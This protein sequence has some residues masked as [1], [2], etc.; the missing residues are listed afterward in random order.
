MNI[1]LLLEVL[2]LLSCFLD[3]LAEISHFDIYFRMVEVFM[4]L[5]K[6]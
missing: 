3:V 5:G 1:D 2:E 4:A 6:A